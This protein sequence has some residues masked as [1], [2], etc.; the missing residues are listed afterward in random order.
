VKLGLIAMSGTRA[1]NAELM[2]L[3]LTLPGF[4]ERGKTI[5]SLPSLGLL[6]LAGMTPP[7]IDVAYVEVRDLDVLP[8]IPDGFDAVAI[9]SFTAQIRQAYRLADMY[10]AQGTRVVLGGLHVTACPDEA[11]RHADSIVIGEGESAW[12]TVAQDLL[13]GRLQPRYD[14]RAASFDLAQAP[15]PRFDLLDVERYNRLTVQTQRG[16]P[17]NCEF[18]A[19]SLRISPRFKLK[20][21]AKVVAEIRRIK[22]LWP[23]PFIELADD[24]TFVDKRRSKELVR[25]LAAEDIRWFTET[26]ISVADDDELLRMMRDSGCAQILVGLESPSRSGLDG[27]EQRSNWKW[28]RG[29]RYAGAIERIQSHGITVNGCFVLGLDHTGPESFDEVLR[30]VRDTGLYE[31][32]ITIMTPFPGTPLY[33]RLRAGGRLL[34]ET[35]WERCSLFDVNFQPAG[36]T[37]SEL[38]TGFRR[39]A[40]SLYS[41]EA[42]R[43]RRRRFV[44]SQRAVA[45]ASS[46][47]GS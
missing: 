43:E 26:D 11:A 12:P 35:A 39:L 30:F 23:Q 14:V 40:E 36:M 4:V 33:D 29:D 25:A 22:E 1:Q 31:V 27:L 47:L 24:N 34:D 21:V 41:A 15:L 8:S 19:S 45:T 5:A 44:R 38:E 6:T 28:K 7:G 37:V 3:G 2:A 18:C 42:T 20:P 9:S 10:R 46:L 13:A 17:Y 32:Q 16:C